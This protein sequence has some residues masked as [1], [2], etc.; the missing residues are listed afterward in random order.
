MTDTVAPIAAHQLSFTYG[1]N[2]V[3]KDVSFSV[4]KGQFFIVIGPNG[5]GKSTLLRT[6]AGL[7]RPKTGHVT[8]MGRPLARHSRR[9]VARQVAFVP[10]STTLSFPFTVQQVVLMG[11]APHLGWP[12]IEGKSDWQAAGEA[13]VFTGT[14]HLADRRINQISGGE[15]QRV[16]L[17]RA[18]CQA[19]KV[20]LLD[21]PTAA[22]DLRHQVHI[23][24]LLEQLIRHLS[25]T[26]IM[27]SHDLNLAAMYA[28]RVLLMADGA[29]AHIGTPDMVLEQK[30][31]ESVYGCPL[32][33]N[34]SPVGAY[35]QIHLLPG[36]HL[37]Q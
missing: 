10:Q 6:L 23:M 25:L 4:P 31:L 13:M 19:P 17:A 26:V 37:N 11:R 18:L 14:D 3:L 20:L 29:I 21:E 9:Q 2:P 34:R 16:F 5:S 15:Q 32:L 8:L 27:V 36:R 35:P 24:D 30:R 33:V 12:A 22:L 1:Q 7:L 28:Q